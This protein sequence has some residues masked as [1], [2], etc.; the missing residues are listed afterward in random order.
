MSKISFRNFVIPIILSLG[1]FS[2]CSNI[3]TPP[4]DL[5]TT[6]TTQIT[7]TTIDENALIPFNDFEV[8]QENN[9]SFLTINQTGMEG[10]Y[11]TI[12][13]LYGNKVIEFVSGDGFQKSGY[14]EFAD[15]DTINGEVTSLEDDNNNE[16]N[17]DDSED[18]TTTEETTISVDDLIGKDGKWTFKCVSEGTDYVEIKL[19]NEYGD[20]R[21]KCQYTCIVDTHL[22]AHM[23]YT[24]I[25][26]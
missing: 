17:Q 18:T 13:M 20:V 15:G 22:E 3:E 16:D 19:I 25:N 9:E 5:V 21:F 7:T 23:Y 14:G 26:Y 12:S 1:L 8:F 24:N 6:T 11:Y 10:C 4:S 2:A